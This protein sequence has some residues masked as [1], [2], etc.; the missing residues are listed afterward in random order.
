M[1]SKME[2]PP[3]DWDTER[4]TQ[5]DREPETDTERNIQGPGQFAPALTQQQGPHFLNDMFLKAPKTNEYK[6][7]SQDTQV[8]SLSAVKWENALPIEVRQY[9]NQMKV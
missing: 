7:K 1:D 9:S 3:L 2:S 4:D 5:R 6:V 8:N